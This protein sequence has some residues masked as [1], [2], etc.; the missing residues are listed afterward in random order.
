MVRVEGVTADA[1]TH[2]GITVDDVGDV[3]VLAVPAA[4]R[5]GLCDHAGPD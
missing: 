5:V 2:L 3:T 4:D 1:L